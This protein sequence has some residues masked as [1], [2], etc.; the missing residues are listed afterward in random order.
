MS[1]RSVV[2]RITRNALLLALLCMIG[3]FSFPLGE[4]LKVS[5]QLWIVFLICFLADGLLDCIIIHA[6]YLLLGLFLPIYAGFATGIS[7][8]FGFVI[9]FVLACPLIYCLNRYLK[10]P[11]IASMA[12]ACVAGLLI[13][14]ASGTIF[15][16]FYL[17]LDL[18]SVLLLAVIPYIPFDIIKIILAIGVMLA[19]PTAVKPHN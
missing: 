4:H 9:G 11:K 6:S 3:M 14:Y 18:G 19:L 2:Q 17:S 7:A 15:M 5:L 1:K 13:V 8:T 16:C 12:I 10:L